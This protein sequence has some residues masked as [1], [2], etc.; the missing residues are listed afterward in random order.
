MTSGH[1]LIAYLAAQ[2]ETH[3]RVAIQTCEPAGVAKYLFSLAQA[4]NHFYHRHRIKDD[5]YRCP[6]SIP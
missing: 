1:D 2:L 4:L 6:T 3:V 5:S